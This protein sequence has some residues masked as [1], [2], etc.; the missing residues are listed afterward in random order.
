MCTRRHTVKEEIGG[1]VVR[2]H[3][4]RERVPIQVL[5]VAADGLESGGATVFQMHILQIAVGD[6][7][8]PY[9]QLFA[10]ARGILCRYGHQL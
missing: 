1:G 9:G 6:N 7:G 2:D 3:R 4:V 10:Q 8:E 5:R